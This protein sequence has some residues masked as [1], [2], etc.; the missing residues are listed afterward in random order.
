MK[1]SDLFVKALEA[2]GVEYVFG[3]PGEENL[4]LL[5][6][7]RRSRIK[8]VLTRHEQAAG[9]MAATYGRLTG[10]TGVCL[11]TLG[12]GATNFVT[13]AAY[14][15]LGGMPMLM[16][17][18]QKPIKSSKQG[19]FQIVDVVDMMQ[20]LTKFTRQIVSI[21]N[22]PSAVREA[23]RRAEEERPGAAHLEL[24]ED[25][26]HEE[27]DGKP[28]PRSY[29]RRP[30]A[31]EKAVAHAVD[32]I[33]AAR[34]PLLMIGAGGNRK[35]TCKMLL[36]FVDKTGIP[37]FTTQMGKGV[38]DETHPL[39]LGNATLS[40]GDFVHRAIE[41]ADCI[42]NVGH[43]VI[44][45]PPFFMRTDDKTVIHVN[46]LGA[47]VDPV[48][49]PQI[50]VVGDIANAVWQ[51]KEALTPQSHWDFERFKMIKAHFDAHLEKG[52]HDPRFP[53]YPVR[54]VN[55]L[56]K[57]LPV[58]GI[59]CL[60]NGMYKIWFARYWRAHEPNSLLLDNALASMGAGL[61]SAIA[62]K[63]VHPQRKVIAVCGDGGFMMNSQELETA[64][65]LKLDIVVMILRD[66]A[67]G[68]IRWKQENMNFPDFAMTLQNP[69]FVSYA[70]SYGAHGHRVESAD[71]LEPLL[72]ECFSSPGVH[73]ID[74]P[75]DYSD[76]ERVLNR[77]I[78]RLSA[79]L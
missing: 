27:G 72:R 19:H 4:D 41:Q 20:P 13:A 40:D 39:W 14:A 64:V 29:S 8:L 47:Q 77:E 28:I 1:A 63:I 61:P 10:R 36:E 74:V 50:E 38:I 76:N 7:L 49:F 44:E 25:I 56:Y 58:D 68:M 66:D 11:A 2:E 3:I 22:I 46:F 23:F 32:A 75:I 9:F 42:I 53:M 57:A 43:D 34:H 24:P 18:G 16:I 51:M 37:F 69:D 35:T 45:K 55:D 5:E 30:V 26:A 31:E 73:V 17:T 62:T 59:V 54:I 71:D 33:K 65:R 67:F 79:Q 21:G 60:D 6:S 70:Q 15:Q 52:Q 78:K 48:Y 12:P